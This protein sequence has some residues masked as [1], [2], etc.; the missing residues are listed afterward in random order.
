MSIIRIEQSNPEFARDNTMTLTLNSTHLG[1][2]RDVTIYNPYSQA[3]DLPVV[4]LL[5][6]VYG[7]N[8]VWMDLGGAH[9]VYEQ[10]RQQGLSEFVLVMPSDGGIWEG[11]AYLPLPHHGN[12]EKWIVEDVIDGVQTTVDSV[13]EHSNLYISGLSMGGY[14]ALRLGAKYATK[15]SGISAH[16]AITK[17]TD[18]ALFT[19]TPLDNY[20]TQVEHESDIVYWCKTNQSQLPPLRFDCGEQDQ[21]F[22]SNQQ[23]T[24][25]LGDANISH[26]FAVNQGSHEW[27]YWHQH[28]QTTL[29]FFDN[30]EKKS[31]SA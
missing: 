24:K 23:L 4:I 31:K 28:L 22:G 18:M 8:W 29:C 21:L 10:L 1:G 6:G 12:F 15:F 2:R 30:I 13:S 16:S 26:Q 25:A 17:V 20:Q 5:H 19:D 9:L 3:K 27:A 14:G 11:S 7:N